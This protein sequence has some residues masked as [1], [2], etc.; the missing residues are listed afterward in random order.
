MGIVVAVV[1]AGKV[2]FIAFPLQMLD[3]NKT[4]P[5]VKIIQE[6]I[7]WSITAESQKISFSIS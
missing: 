2:Q 3:N 6:F 4:T 1:C 5:T 7:P